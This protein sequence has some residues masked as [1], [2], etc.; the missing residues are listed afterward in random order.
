MIEID[1]SQGEGGGQVLRSALSLSICTGQPFR[2]VRIRAKRPTPGLMRQHLAAV[3]AAAS[4]CGAQTAGAAPGSTEIDF[5]PGRVRPGSYAF[6]IGTAG[7]TT[8]VF[9]TV[10]MPLL[11]ASAASEVRIAGGTHNRAAPP[12]DFV[13]RAF[14]PVLARMGADVRFEV[15]RHGFHPR[16]GGEIRAAI[17]RTTGLRRLALH[18][19]GAPTRRLAEAFVASLPAEIGRRELAVVARE[20]GWAAQELRLRDLGRGSGPGNALTITAGFEHVTEVFTGFGERGVPAEAVA[21]A[22][23]REAQAYL[24]AA[25]PVGEHLADQLLVPLALGPGGSFTATV[26]SEHLRT[27]AAIVERFTGRRVRMDPGPAGQRVEIDPA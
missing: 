5:R 7:S 6:E 22:A 16:G 4:I 17:A 10:L 19:R 14:L 15:L 21:A 11:L 2:M 9:Q 23:V 20:L 12:A 8:L 13:E 25:A 3:R 26:G 18:E 1:G 27:N 24:A